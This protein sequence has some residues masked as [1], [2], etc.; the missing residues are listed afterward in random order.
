MT[1][2]SFYTPRS[3]AARLVAPL[4]ATAVSY[5]PPRALR[6]LV[7]PLREISNHSRR[8][9]LRRRATRAIHLVVGDGMSMRVKR[10]HGG[11]S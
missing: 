9:A 11:R 8:P 4:V 2:L 5:L 10:Q 6:P 3:P 7:V 1:K